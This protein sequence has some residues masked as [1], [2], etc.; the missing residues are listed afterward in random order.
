VI[1]LRAALLGNPWVLL[2]ACAALLASYGVVGVKAYRMGQDK[3]IA[4]TAR[5][6]DQEVRT[7]DAALAAAAEAISQIEV[8]NVTIRQKAETITREVPVYRDCRHGGD[9]L[10][11]LNR[12]LTDTP[13]PAAG[14]QLPAPDPAGR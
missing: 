11:L 1:P 3:V 13:E 8:R 9:G 4:E 12:A 2:A 10:R 14:S 5:L 6:L 7:R